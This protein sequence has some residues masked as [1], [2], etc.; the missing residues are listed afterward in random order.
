MSD[1]FTHDAPA[2][3]DDAMREA[4]IA[5]HQ[6]DL[7]SMADR[8]YIPVWLECDVIL[9]QDEARLINH[10]ADNGGILLSRVTQGTSS[11]PMFPDLP[12]VTR[13]TTAALGMIANA[14]AK[15]VIERCKQAG[16]IVESYSEADEC[17]R[18]DC[19]IAGMRRLERHEQE[20]EW[21]RD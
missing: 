17:F 14:N 5:S 4:M 16:W 21:D 20:K 7:R 13:S 11:T 18:L 15:A 2:N 9:Q 10:I 19:T 1:F 8:G 6:S 12:R 3:S